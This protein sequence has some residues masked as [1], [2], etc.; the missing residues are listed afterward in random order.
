MENKGDFINHLIKKVQSAAFA[1][2][3]DVPSFVDWLDGQLCTLV[4]L[5][6]S[7]VNGYNEMHILKPMIH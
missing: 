3:E 2:I 7:L 4:T 1:D 5:T 6:D